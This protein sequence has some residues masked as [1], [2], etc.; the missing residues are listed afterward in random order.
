MASLAKQMERRRSA[1][2]ADGFA[3]KLLVRMIAD[4]DLDLELRAGVHAL[5][6]T[7]EEHGDNLDIAEELE[8]IRRW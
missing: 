4:E 1:G 2:G 3:I 8:C 5:R 6:H 7:L